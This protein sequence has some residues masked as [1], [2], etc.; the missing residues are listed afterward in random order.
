MNQN[1]I[2]SPKLVPIGQKVPG[3]KAI[4]PTDRRQQITLDGSRERT[5]GVPTIPRAMRAV[6]P[7]VDKGVIVPAGVKVTRGPSWTHDPR[8][9]CRPGDEPF[10]AGFS[11]VGIGRDI[12]TGRAW[13]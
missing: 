4:A 13:E 11:S 10:G 8:Y 3:V 2:K 6:K 9:Q 12:D 5:V 7:A 1:T